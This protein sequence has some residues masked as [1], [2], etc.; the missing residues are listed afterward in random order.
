MNIKPLHNEAD[1]REA[2][3]AIERLWDA[4]PGTPSGDELEVLAT[5]VDD[6]ERRHHPILPP[7]PIEAI[8]F[9]LDQQGQ[10]RKVL[11]PLLGSRARVSEVLNRR[12]ALTLAMIRA[13]H[14]KLDIPLEV[15]VAEVRTKPAPARR[16]RRRRVR[17]A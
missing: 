3:G 13:L 15:L 4:R 2:L 9:R 5:L 17:A 7:D 11:E 12:R 10:S 8:K 14:A 16:T 6:Y 1:Y